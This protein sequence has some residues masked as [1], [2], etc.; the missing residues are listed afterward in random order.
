M[1]LRAPR[2]LLVGLA[3]LAL[4]G[5][6]VAGTLLVMN[7]STVEGGDGGAPESPPEEALAVDARQCEQQTDNLLAGLDGLETRLE[8]GLDYEEYLKRV[9]DVRVAYE[10]I[11]VDDL[12]LECLEVAAAAE[13]ALRTHLEA[14]EVWT[15]CVADRN[16]ENDSIRP[17][18]RKTWGKASSQLEESRQALRA[19]TQ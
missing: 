1:P 17:K 11:P 18:L 14:A 15:R 9:G 12:G 7:E 2:W 3:S 16:C 6:G 5:V 4:I 10:R 19:L 8:I 13:K